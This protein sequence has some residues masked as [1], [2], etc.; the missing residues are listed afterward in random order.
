MYKIIQGSRTDINPPF[1]VYLKQDTITFQPF[2]LTEVT[3]ITCCF[4][5]LDGSELMLTLESGISIVGN[6]L[7]GVLLV[8]LTAVQTALLAPVTEETLELSLIFGDDTDPTKVQIPKAYYVV[9]SIC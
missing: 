4:E 1:N 8:T 7:L 5:N 2:D 9:D 3:E 6:P